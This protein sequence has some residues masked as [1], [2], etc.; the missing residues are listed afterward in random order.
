MNA[1]VTL[2]HPRRLFF[3]YWPDAAAR[4][5]LLDA[6]RAAVAAIDGQPVGPTSLHVTIAFIGK[7]PGARI[8]DLMRIGGRGDYPAADLRFD[9]LEY[10]PR[11]KAV[12]ALPE[13]IPAA[14]QRLVEVLWER[15]QPLEFEREARAWRPHVTI[16][17][18]MRRP[19]PR[20]AI[21]GVH[22]PCN[23]LALVESMS[24]PDGM[25]YTALAEWPLGS[26][27]AAARG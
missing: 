13:M 14:G 3:A 7:V 12:V 6:T 11:A 4:R 18:R 22:W 2:G 19:P 5:A 24:A 23:R 15:L 25:H 16:V 26:H 9:H 8:P 20:L 17:R 21:A 27:S 1:T 10:W